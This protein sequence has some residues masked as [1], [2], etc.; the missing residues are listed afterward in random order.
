[1]TIASGNDHLPS[2]YLQRI[3]QWANFFWQHEVAENKK[4]KK[5][6]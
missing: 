1:M 3:K 2:T 5:K 4:K 6:G